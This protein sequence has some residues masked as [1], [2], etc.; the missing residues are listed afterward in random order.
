MGIAE[1]PRRLLAWLRE[2]LD[3]PYGGSPWYAGDD[4]PDAGDDAVEWP[5]RH[6]WD[7]LPKRSAGFGFSARDYEAA[8]ARAEEIARLTARRRRLAAG[9]ARRLRRSAVPS[10]PGRHLPAA[11]RA[12][13][14]GPLRPRGAPAVA[15][16]LPLHQPDLPPTGGRVLRPPLPLRP[17]PRGRADPGRR[18]P[19]V[20]PG[21]R[22]HVLSALS[23]D[24]RRI[25]SASKGAMCRARRRSLARQSRSKTHRTQLPEHAPW[26]A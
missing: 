22:P 6:R 2:G 11:D 14:R 9:P 18:P 25:A 1:A 7:H 26:P 24:I 4:L 13:D 16:P 23:G 21:A 20:G 15:P 8:R 5:W 3:E 17:R 10:L 12:P 19:T